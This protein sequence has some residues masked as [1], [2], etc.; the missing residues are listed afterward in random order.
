LLPVF[1][2]AL[3]SITDVPRT[4]ARGGFTQGLNLDALGKQYSAKDMRQNYSNGYN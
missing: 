3:G 2:R 4:A 1:L